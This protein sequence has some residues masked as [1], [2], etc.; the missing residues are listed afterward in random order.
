MAAPTFVSEAE[1]A[2]NS[3]TSPKSTGSF[4]VLTGDIL[5]PVAVAEASGNF[6]GADMTF[7]ATGGSLTYNSQQ[8]VRI[9]DYTG[10]EAWIAEATGDAS[11]AGTI[12]RTNGSFLFFGGNFP[13]FRDSDGV[14]ASAK[15]NVLS[16]AP[17]LDITTTQDNSAIVVVVGDW[18]AADGASRT[19]RTVNGT[20]PSAANGFELTY[21]RDSSRYT[22]Y[23]A[24][25]P[26][27][28][29]AGAKTVGLSAPTGQKYSII[30][31]EVKGTAAAGA[32]P[33]G[34]LG[35]PF[36]GPFGGAI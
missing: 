31:V 8:S 3:T 27:A 20:A 33:K 15:T 9:S 24:Y 11:F 13:V 26:D 2:W 5:C 6:G 14:G 17:S 12:T 21:F 35:N 4:D 32:N 30:A 34:P 29:A 23:V 10:I 28:G 16:G 36:L 1:T 25:Y 18:N 19:W 22:L 7:A